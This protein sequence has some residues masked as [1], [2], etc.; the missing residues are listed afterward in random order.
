MKR[1]VEDKKNGF[2]VKHSPEKIADAIIKI[3]SNDKLRIKMGKESLKKRYYWKDDMER[4]K[5]TYKRL[6]KNE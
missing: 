1:Y 6:I 3:L 4:L 5:R 2:I